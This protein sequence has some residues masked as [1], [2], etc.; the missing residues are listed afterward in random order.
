MSAIKL[1]Q[2]AF[3]KEAP[4]PLET[5]TNEKDSRIMRKSARISEMARS[6]GHLDDSSESHPTNIVDFIMSDIQLED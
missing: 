4:L 2:E 6:V 3:T 5:S 1:A